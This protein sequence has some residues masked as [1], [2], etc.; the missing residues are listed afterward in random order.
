MTF[1]P[2]QFVLH[3]LVYWSVLGSTVIWMVGLEPVKRSTCRHTVPSRILITQMVRLSKLGSV[4][5]F[6][7]E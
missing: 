3:R 5:V 6:G 4:I 2:K 7:M 1:D